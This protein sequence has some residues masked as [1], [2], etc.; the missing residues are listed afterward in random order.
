MTLV[1]NDVNRHFS[2]PAANGKPYVKLEDPNPSFTPEE[3][4]NHYANIHPE[5]TTATVSG[6]KMTHNG[7]EYEFKS[8]VGTKG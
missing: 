8:T 1:I 6:P 2:I 4:M 3:V 7:A 5:L